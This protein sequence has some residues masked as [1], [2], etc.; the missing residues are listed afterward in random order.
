MAGKGKVLSDHRWM[1]MMT[2]ISVSILGAP[3]LHENP[4]VTMRES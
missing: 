3:G 4:R 2:R 1:P